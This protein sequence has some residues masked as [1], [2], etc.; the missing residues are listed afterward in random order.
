M[1]VSRFKSMN[2]EVENYFRDLDRWGVELARL[3][4]IVMRS[5]LE[6][7]LKWGVPC[8]MKDGKNICLL[9][10]FNEFV[11]VSFFKGALLKKNVDKLVR[12][13]SNSN[14]VKLLK[15]HS[16]DEINK[17]EQII[18]ECIEEAFEIER[19]G[20]QVEKVIFSS[21]D[22]PQEL[23]ERFE[24]DSAFQEAFFKLTPGR[25]RGFLLF[26]K[27]AK[28]SKTV[29]ARIEKHYQRIHDGYGIHDC[30]CGLSQRMPT[31][32]GSH[33]T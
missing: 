9:G 2:K 28:Q 16:I 31:C 27:S 12:P 6:E 25:Q 33:K 10:K 3:R 18:I 8:Y 26:F 20:L 29:V 13:G 1:T 5:A 23:I 7:T 32:D 21:S 17:A 24:V 14:H 30:T 19:L 4:E 22:Y 15:F 11:S